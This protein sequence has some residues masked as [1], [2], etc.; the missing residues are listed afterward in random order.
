M[1]NHVQVHSNI[2]YLNFTFKTG[3]YFIQKSFYIQNIKPY[4]IFFGK[5]LVNILS[6]LI[7]KI[8]FLVKILFKYFLIFTKNIY[9]KFEMFKHFS[10][11]NILYLFFQN[12]HFKN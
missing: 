8:L 7:Y 10:N 6:F 2:F 4:F 3:K 9:F 12:Q 5:Y 1:Q 11:F